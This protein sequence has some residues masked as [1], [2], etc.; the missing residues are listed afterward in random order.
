MALS[1]TTNPTLNGKYSARLPIPFRATS[2]DDWILATVRNSDGTSAGLSTARIPKVSGGFTFNPAAYARD[3]FDPFDL[4]K[5]EAD[6]FSDLG[7]DMYRLL[8]VLVQEEDSPAATTSNHFYVT[9]G[10]SPIIDTGG[11]RETARWHWTQLGIFAASPFTQ[12]ASYWR[13]DREWTYNSHLRAVFYAGSGIVST[14]S[15]VYDGSTIVSIAAPGNEGI[16][17]LPLNDTWV[18]A[19]ASLGSVPASWSTARLIVTYS[20]LGESRQM[21]IVRDNRCAKTLIYR[22]RYGAWDT[23]VLHGREEESVEGSAAGL[24]TVR[25]DVLDTYDAGLGSEFADGRVKAYGTRSEV[26]KS[27]ESDVIRPSVAAYL[28]RDIVESP[29]HLI[30]E[31]DATGGEAIREI[32]IDRGASTVSDLGRGRSFTLNYSYAT[33][34]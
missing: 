3:L 23:F 33:Q 4:T 28:F 29:V 9:P 16:Y 30:V 24:A 10:A 1:I 32:I 13:F 31:E 26:S 34:G 18:N 12:S 6:S 7:D 14:I 11:T 15:I 17:Q 19:N 25:T 22:N 8:E 20:S 21:E 5:V 2:G 27:I